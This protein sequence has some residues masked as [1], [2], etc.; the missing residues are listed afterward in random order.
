MKKNLFKSLLIFI[1]ILLFLFF[2]IQNY[3]SAVSTELKENIFRLHIIA[4]SNSKKDQELKIKVRDV[5]IEYLNNIETDFN[6]KNE[7][8][9]YVQ[10]HIEEIKSLVKKTIK[11][12]NFDYKVS[13]EIGESYFPTKYY[14]NI[15]LPAGIYDAIKIKIGDAKGENWWCSLFP[16]LCFNNFSNGFI[17]TSN[18]KSLEKNLSKEELLIITNSSSTYQFKFKLIEILN[19]KNI[20]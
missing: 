2:N 19:N 18:S 9:N 14:E 13:I 16:P 3:A 8:I 17:S 5:I 12:N 1:L 15:S 20:L 7:M 4:N 11:E 6:S 10:T